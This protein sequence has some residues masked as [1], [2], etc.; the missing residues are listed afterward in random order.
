MYVR[1]SDFSQLLDDHGM[2]QSMRVMKHIHL[3]LFDMCKG[4]GWREVCVRYRDDVYFKCRLVPAPA[5][6]FN[7]SPLYVSLALL[8][9]SLLNTYNEYLTDCNF[10]YFSLAPLGAYSASGIY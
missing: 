2:F 8:K 9:V 10:R 6:Q 5:E 1:I 4:P 7:K 3:R